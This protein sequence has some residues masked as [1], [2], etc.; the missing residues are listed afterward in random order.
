MLR[1]CAPGRHVH[2]GGGGGVGGARKEG[3]DVLVLAL[4][5]HRIL[6]DVCA[7]VIASRRQAEDAI[8]A[9][10]VGGRSARPR[11]LF[12]ALHILLAEDLHVHVGDGF[13]VLVEHASGDHTLRREAHGEV[14]GFLARFEGEQGAGLIRSAG[15]VLGVDEA[16]AFRGE[17]VL[18][19]GD[20]GDGELAGGVGGGGVADLDVGH[21]GR[22]VDAPKGDEGAA[23]RFAGGGIGYLAADGT[24]IAGFGLGRQ[25]ERQQEERTDP[26][27]A[28]RVAHF[29]AGHRARSLHGDGA[30]I[31]ETV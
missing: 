10:I 12:A 16:A 13:A 14:A 2:G 29:R 1:N 31:A 21:A 7:H 4:G 26:T 6:P 20:P 8:F 24:G 5:Q 22:H 25:R 17:A 9:Q 11:H 28:F 30:R 19:G 3:G 23:H 27:H 15:A 18:A